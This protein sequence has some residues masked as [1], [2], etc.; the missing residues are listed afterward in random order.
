VADRYCDLLCASERQFTDDFERLPQASQALL[1]RLIM[2]K[3]E[4]FRE[5]K[6]VYAEIGSI[7]EAAAALIDL[8]WLDP[9]PALTVDELF[10]LLMRAE[11]APIFSG[12]RRGTSKGDALEILRPL[13]AEPQTLENWMAH[14]GERVF[15]VSV[16][17]LCTQLRIL[18]FGNFRQQWS[19]FVLAD[20]QV[21]KYETVE[22]STHSRAFQSREEIEQFYAPI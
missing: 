12:L 5:S 1:V 15:R 6:I 10:G 22:V 18:F 11:L 13:Y 7:A 21:F 9:N 8:Q 16:V 2:R 17:R 20:L 3:G 14:Y 4:L 19:E